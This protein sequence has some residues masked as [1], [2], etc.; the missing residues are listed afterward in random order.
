MINYRNLGIIKKKNNNN[1]SVIT[2]KKYLVQNVGTAHRQIPK[3]FGKTPVLIG[4][5]FVY[6]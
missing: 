1:Y 2:F 4:M 5:S 6:N 3:V